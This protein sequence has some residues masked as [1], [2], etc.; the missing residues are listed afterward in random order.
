MRS[1]SATFLVF[2]MIGVAIAA[3]RLALQILRRRRVVL[4]RVR[5]HSHA[6]EAHLLDEVTQLGELGLKILPPTS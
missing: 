2:A 5:K 3:A 1:L 6:F 4:G